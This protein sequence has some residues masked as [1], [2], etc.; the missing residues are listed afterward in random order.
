MS[1]VIGKDRV[2]IV[3]ILD[4]FLINVYVQ[5]NFISFAES[6]TPFRSIIII[7]YNSE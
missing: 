5:T 4:T 2:V 7:I 1:S 6:E 3:I